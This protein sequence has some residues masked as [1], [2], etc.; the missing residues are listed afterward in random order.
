MVKPEFKG[1]TRFVLFLFALALVQ[2]TGFGIV[3]HTDDEPNDRPADEVVGRWGSSGSCVVISPNHV[4]T[5]RHQGGGAGTTVKIGGTNYKVAQ[6]S[7]ISVGDP[8]DLRV[9]R[10]TTMDGQLAN[11]TDYVPLYT[12]TQETQKSTTMGGFGKRRGST[13]YTNGMA[14]GYTWVGT[15]NTTLRWGSNEIN[16]YLYNNTLSG[17]TSDLIWGRFNDVGTGNYVECEASIA[18]W[19]S[20]G[21]WFVKDDGQ[22]KIAGLFRGIETHPGYPNQTWFRDRSDPNILHP[23]YFDAVRVSR[24][25]EDITAEITPPA[26][27]TNVTAQTGM[28]CGEIDLVWETSAGATGYRIYYQEDLPGPPFE[29]SQN[30][31]PASTS[32]VGDVNEITITG[33]TPGID[34][35]FAVTAHKGIA[36]SDYSEDATAM[37]SSWL[38]DD[39]NDSVRSANWRLRQ[40]R[41]ESASLAE[42]NQRLEFRADMDVN[43]LEAA[44][45]SNEWN[46]GTT[47]DFSLKV[48]FHHELITEQDSRVFISVG[49]GTERNRISFEAGCEGNSP[50]WRYEEVV[51]GNVIS[52]G[53]TA[54]DSN[55]GTL[56]LSYDAGGDELYLSHTGY[57][58]GNDWQMIS[59][60]LQGQWADEPIYVHIGGGSDN[61][62]VGPGE[63]YLDNFTVNSGIL[64]DWPPA[65]DINDDGFINWLDVEVL[66]GQWLD[67]GEGLDADINGDS[68]ADFKD[69]AEFANAW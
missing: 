23:D 22:W 29:P 49:T 62:A 50:Y 14:Y 31:K 63:V 54:R 68:K 42:T 28:A 69:F 7:N 66:S 4:L 13:L 1:I 39:F 35:Y 37:A 55:D 43:N 2:S 20:G 34:Y 61:V 46:F 53:Q 51:D 3:L 30:G 52:A 56:Y 60:L 32:Y 57:G 18:S 6:I 44:Y 24:Y 59:G 67:T 40:D 17:Y 27:P 9:A 64:L 12:G 45:V 47:K 15:S 26:I 36:V 8:A 33:L 10:V 48:D 58:S 25:D 41:P 11:L 65:T 19:D 5:T 16:D 21:G 38:L